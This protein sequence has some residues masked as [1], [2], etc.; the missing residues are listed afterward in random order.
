[1]FRNVLLSTAVLTVLSAMPAAATTD[2]NVQWSN[3]T[4]NG[5]GCPAGTAVVTIT[6]DGDEIAWTFDSFGFDLVGPSSAS[7]FCRISASAK[8][9]GGYY[10]GDLKQELTYGGIKSTVGSRLSVGA[11]SRFFGYN[12]PPMVRDY[13]DG[14]AFDSLFE[15]A[16]AVNSFVVHAPPSY[17][18]KSGGVSGLF[19]STLSANGQVTAANGSA[20]LAVQGQNVTFKATSGWVACPPH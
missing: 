9:S 19:Q 17:F 5:N 6:P 3:A 18:C 20:S 4:A 16:V 11:Q 2:H 13:P 1:M 12:L 15:S 8:L 7:R 14:K 10:L